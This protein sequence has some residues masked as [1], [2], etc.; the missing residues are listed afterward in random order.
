MAKLM[1]DL[2]WKFWF[3][4]K[5]TRILVYSNH[6]KLHKRRNSES[7]KMHNSSSFG[8]CMQYGMQAIGAP[9]VEIFSERAFLFGFFFYQA[10]KIQ[11]TSRILCI[12]CS[13][14]CAS[15]KNS[16]LM[17]LP[18]CGHGRTSFLIITRL[19]GF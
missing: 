19:R 11:I 4:F 1:H 17:K 5:P 3:L 13:R 18:W 10:I 15:S 7:E 12:S 16:Y 8:E 6:W 2:I 9:W 14:Y